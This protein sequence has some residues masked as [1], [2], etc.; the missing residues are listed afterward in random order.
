MQDVIGMD[1]MRMV[2]E[3]TDAFGIDR[4]QVRVSL[5]KTDP[6]LVAGVDS[7]KKSDVFSR[8]V[9]VVEITIPLTIPLSS[10]IPVLRSSL[11]DLG[12]SLAK[13]IDDED[14]D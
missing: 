1:D 14:L 12:F 6:G 11:L 9:P 10:W 4:E 5:E 3:V 2:F 8:T 7:D 13:G